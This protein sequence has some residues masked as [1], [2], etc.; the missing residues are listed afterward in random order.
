MKV[1]IKKEKRKDAWTWHHGSITDV[2][3]KKYPFTLLEKFDSKT[4]ES[5]YEV[6]FPV[7]TPYNYIEAQRQIVKT[8]KAQ[9]DEKDV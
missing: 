8:F 4:N 7:D 2:H 5:T 9:H 6:S 1:T 3:D